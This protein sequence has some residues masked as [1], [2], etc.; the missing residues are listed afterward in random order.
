VRSVA[1]SR[2]GRWLASAGEDG[3]VRLWPVPDLAKPPLHTRPHEELLA[4]LRSHTNLRAVP[5]PQ[6]PTGYRI[7]P[8]PFPGWARLPRW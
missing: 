3:T 5:D 2:D 1:F 4:V 7:E 8:G 6:S